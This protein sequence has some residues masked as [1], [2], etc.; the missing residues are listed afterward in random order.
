MTLYETSS[1]R[2][3]HNNI[4]R[5]EITANRKAASIM[6]IFYG[7]EMAT[8]LKYDMHVQIRLQGMHIVFLKKV[9]N[10]LVE[11]IRFYLLAG[12]YGE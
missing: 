3:K 7:E 10:E 2:S 8:W 11:Y 9:V 4:I 1:T 5:S 12:F 6:L